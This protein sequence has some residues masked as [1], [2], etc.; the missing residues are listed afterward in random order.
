LN[1]AE[2]LFQRR[3]GERAVGAESGIVDEDLDQGPR[4][5][6]LARNFAGSSRIGEIFRQRRRASAELLLESPRDLLEPLP[7]PCHQD[8]IVSF[9]REQRCQ[10]EPDAARGPG[11]EHDRARQESRL[12]SG[13]SIP[14]TGTPASGRGLKRG[15]GRTT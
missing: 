2:L 5:V 3:L 8:E 11:D 12:E 7:A 1:H 13:E 14:G 4:P 9:P 10:L 6:E 15:F